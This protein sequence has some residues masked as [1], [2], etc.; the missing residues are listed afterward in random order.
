M[1]DSQTTITGSKLF[2]TIAAMLSSLMAVLD[3]S[4]VNVA[5]NDIRASFGVQVDQIAWVSTGY[6]MA[7]VIVIPLTGWFQRRFGL[8]NYFIF[9]VLLF[10]FASLLCGM[11]WNLSSLTVFRIVQG[12]GGGAIIPTA[13]TLLMARYP[14]E[15]QGMAQAFIGLGAITGPLLGPSLGGYLIEIS[16]WHMIFLINI[17]FGL[18][19]AFLA[20]RNIEEVQFVP[21]TS[22]FDYKGVALL[23][24]GF[25][26][27]QY[28]IEEGNRR[29]WLEDNLIVFLSIVTVTCVVT[30]IVQQLESVH[31]MVNF[32][33][34][35]N[36]NYILCSI[37]NFFLGVC[38]FS[39]SFLF[40]LFCGT[41]L[42]YSP[43]D[44]GLLFLKGC[45]IQ[46]IIM[47]I[48]GKIIPKV[49]GRILIVIGI[50]LVG[51]SIMINAKLTQ[52]TPNFDLILVL[53]VRSLG[54]ASVFIPLSVIAIDQIPRKDFGN[55]IGLFNLTREL[56]G[57]I[58]LAIMSS[59][60]VN[61]MHMFDEYLKSYLSAD[62]P[63]MQNQMLVMK[64]MFYGNAADVDKTTNLYIQ[65]RVTTQAYVQSFSLSFTILSF[66]FFASLILVLFMKRLNSQQ[67]SIE[68]LH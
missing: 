35:T 63:I 33:V 34:F 49:D 4:I 11:S 30:F 6:M 2:I 15:Q 46:V 47:P 32:R 7:N 61:R 28:V 57:S 20:F 37:M 13:S 1:Q 36:R 59:S 52:N 29:G 45:L 22:P 58:G 65:S 55:A 10:T 14:R 25:G 3:I 18:L 54:L 40:S 24:C 42:H 66:I 26:S 64:Y 16:T 44:I 60:L 23:V 5:I 50:L 12:L 41:L 17:P 56:G 9:S 51:T 48:I 43:L 38:L 8:R 19:A 67:A 21:H 62:N 27:L 68:I 31:P 53:F 39:A